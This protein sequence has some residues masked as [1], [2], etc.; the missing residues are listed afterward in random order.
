MPPEAFD[1]V[2]VVAACGKFIFTMIYT[3]VLAVTNVDE[4]IIATPAVRVATLL[5]PV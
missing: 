3:K 2:D 1:T 4:T 5:C